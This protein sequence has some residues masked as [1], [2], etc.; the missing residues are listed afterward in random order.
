MSKKEASNTIPNIDLGQTYDQ[1]YEG[2]D[3]HIDS[4]HNLSSFFGLNMPAHRHDR[5]YQVH[6]L[7]TGKIQVTLGDKSYQGTAPLFYFTPPA[8][9]HAFEVDEE[10]NGLVLT[11]HQHIVRRL[12]SGNDDVAGEKRLAH[13]MFCEIGTLGN[14]HQHEAK[15]LP[16]LMQMLADEFYDQRP[17]RR[18]MLPSLVNL[19]M[20]TVFRLSN[21]PD[22]QLPVKRSDLEI[23][24]NF[25]QL[26][27]QHYHSHQS[28]DSYANT[29]NITGNRLGDIC[30][31]VCGSSPKSLVFERQI[32]EAKWQLLYTAKPISV[33]SAELGFKDPAYFC[34]FFTRNSRLSPREFRR[35]SLQNRGTTLK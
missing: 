2:A 20:V 25:N 18:H 35:I 9:P 15:R 21:L 4:L 27:E 3:I 16:Q 24:Q 26:I 19:V 10:A 34:R 29:L 33:I 7:N 14:E 32:Q 17:G 12:I 23:F 22:Q 13:P 1:R 8:I 5:F 31:R 11:V 6:W 28:L 30:R